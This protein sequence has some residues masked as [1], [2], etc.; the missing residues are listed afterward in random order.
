M[1]LI[2]HIQTQQQKEI[3]INYAVFGEGLSINIH[4]YQPGQSIILPEA[5]DI[6]S[7]TENNCLLFLST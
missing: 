1:C 3:V 4:N 6:Y 2:K 5:Q 7:L